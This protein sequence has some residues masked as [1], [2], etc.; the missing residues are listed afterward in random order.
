MP[1]SSV[2]GVPEPELLTLEQKLSFIEETATA[3]LLVD[4]GIRFIEA[5]EGGV[6]RRV[7]GLHLLAQGFERL[8]KLTRALGQ[9][10]L[11]GRLPTASESRKWG[12]RLV[13]LLD[14]TLEQFEADSDFAARSAIREDIR[15]LRTDRHLRGLFEVLEEFGNGGRYHDLDVMLDGQSSADSP[16]DGWAACEK[17][18][19]DADPKWS[20]LVQQDPGRW[21]T[22]WY[23]HLAATQTRTLQRTARALAR[24]WT[25]GPAK[26]IGKQLSGHLTRF[27][28]LADD[29]LGKCPPRIDA[30]A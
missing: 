5:W 13:Q 12:H 17:A 28:F 26:R 29:A 14:D 30:D 23:P 11:N 22:A 18:L 25:L 3:V 10:Q 4:E 21:G 1:L 16:I 7:V 9:L 19:F 24:A 2:V 6:D 15:F 27:L 20:R 8:L